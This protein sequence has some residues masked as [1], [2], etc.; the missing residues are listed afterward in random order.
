MLARLGGV[1]KRIVHFRNTS[2]GK[3]K[4]LIRFVRN[5]FLKLL[6]HLSATDILSVS[7]SSM[8]LAWSNNWSKDK[9]C[10]IIYNGIL[11]NSFSH[12]DQRSNLIKELNLPDEALLFVHVGRF[13]VAKNHKR[14]V[15]IFE[16]IAQ[17]V[18]HAY[19]LVVGNYQTEHAQTV[20]PLS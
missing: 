1:K 20:L 2:D 13:D 12:T 16:A 15:E 18:D 14:L 5:T 3:H 7:Q 6:I 4:G 11:S 10:H 19:F 17:H 8:I 9:R